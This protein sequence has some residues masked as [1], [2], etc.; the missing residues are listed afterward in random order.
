MAPTSPSSSPPTHPCSLFQKCWLSLC[1]F[2]LCFLSVL[3]R[4]D[5]SSEVY[6]SILHLEYSPSGC[7]SL[8][9][10]HQR[11]LNKA[12]PYH[13]YNVPS[14][15]MKIPVLSYVCPSFT[16]FIL[17]SSLKLWYCALL[18]WKGHWTLQ[19]LLDVN[20]SYKQQHNGASAEKVFYHNLHDL[21]LFLF[22][23][24]LSLCHLLLRG[25]RK[26][27]IISILWL[28]T[29]PNTQQAFNV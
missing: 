27:H 19:W 21:K 8:S 14:T 7:W 4:L 20:H 11:G 29:M 25:L 12:F 3:I 22:A 1:A 5:P 26:L 28:R 2:S 17:E 18:Q 9:Y 6:I 24:T 16:L 10:S 13:S 23:G 15:G